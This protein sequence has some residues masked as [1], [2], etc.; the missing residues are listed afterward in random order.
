MDK[1]PV[2]SSLS[3]LK[4]GIIKKLAN[5]HTLTRGLNYFNEGRIVNPIVWDQTIQAEVIGSG[6]LNYTASVEIK[7]NQINPYCNCPSEEYLCKHIIALLY[8]WIKIP[9]S[10]KEITKIE[11]SLERRKKEE[12]IKLLIT[13]IKK[14]PSIISTLNLDVHHKYENR[15]YGDQAVLPLDFE[16]KNYKQ[17][18]NLL[19]KLREI[20]DTTQNYFKKNDFKNG[21]KI[22]QVIIQHSIRNYKKTQDIDGIFAEFIEECLYDYLK[23]SSKFTI[24]KKEAFFNDFIELY[25]QDS[26]GFGSSILEVILKQCH[27]EADYTQLERMILAKLS[28]LKE[29]EQKNSIIELLLELYDKKGDTDRYLEV[30]KNNLNN[31]RNYIRLCDKLQQ[32]GRFNEAI[33]WYQKAIKGSDSYPKLILKKK[34][35]IIYEKIHKENKALDIHFEVFKEQGDL[36]SYKRMK[37]LF[38]ELNKWE[39]VRN[40]ILMFLSKEKKYPLLIEILIYENDIDSAIKIA[41]LPNQRVSE[42]KKVAKLSID[43]RPT[44]AIKLFKRLINYYIGLRRRDDYRLAKEYCQEVK[45]LYKRL[46]QEHIFKGYIERIRRLNAGKKLLLEELE[47]I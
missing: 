38:S 20:K 40:N 41:L 44:Q 36:E 1:T 6:L 46:N 4:E 27:N 31:W 42:I 17:L 18:G 43:K 21:L 34:L 33:Q 24:P 39:K 14:D 15:R 7:N 47:E 45:K 22:L 3:D 10:F 8:A 23:F 5:Y 30:C 19:N 35:A 16:I 28:S 26:G 11:S 2:L 29:D 32:L 9:E 13:M 12:L 25:L 37:N